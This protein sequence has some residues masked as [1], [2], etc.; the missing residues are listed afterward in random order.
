MKLKN[1][2]TAVQSWCYE[3]YLSKWIYE[4]THRQNTNTYLPAMQA[5][6]YQ[7]L[8]PN[9]AKRPGSKEPGLFVCDHPESINEVFAVK[10]MVREV[11]SKNGQW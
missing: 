10:T 7:G 9:H 6:Y 2:I 11:C 1:P 4:I 3:P 8:I 5:G